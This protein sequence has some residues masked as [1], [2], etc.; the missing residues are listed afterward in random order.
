MEYRCT[1]NF[2]QGAIMVS[3]RIAWQEHSQVTIKY[4][5]CF[6]IAKDKRGKGK[7]NF[8]SYLQ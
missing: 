1:D 4:S 6:K 8:G 2:S 7:Q 3:V 5:K